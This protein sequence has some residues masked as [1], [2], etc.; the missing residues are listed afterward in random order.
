MR[1]AFYVAT[2]FFI[3]SSTRTAAESVQIKSAITQYHDKLPAS[4]S[5]TKTLPG[6]SLKGS[7][8]HLE[9]PVAEEERVRLAE[10]P[11]RVR[12]AEVLGRVRLAEVPERV[13]L[14][15]VLGRVRFA[16]LPERVRLALVLE[17]V[18]LAKVSEL[19]EAKNI[20]PNL[21]LRLRKAEKKLEEDL[22]EMVPVGEHVGTSATP[23]RQESQI[24]RNNL[25]DTI[26]KREP[27]N[28]NLVRAEKN[29]RLLTA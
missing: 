17:R 23:S 26:A 11:E 21:V 25:E 4:G 6:R 28:I 8:D 1:G 19:E 22:R 12:L 16:E 9:T 14:A 27:V 15:E 3:A 5:D 18:R 20:V 13:R 10:V 24:L 2:A 29:S 7:G